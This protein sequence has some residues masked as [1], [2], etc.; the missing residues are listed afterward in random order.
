MR[1][2]AKAIVVVAACFLLATV[3]P[4]VLL[5]PFV[6]LVWLFPDEVTQLYPQA[7]EAFSQ[8][9][10]DEAEQ[11]VR[12][13]LEVSEKARE[14]AEELTRRRQEGQEEA[15]QHDKTSLCLFFHPPAQ[16]SIIQTY[17]APVIH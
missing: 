4:L 6:G 7:V 9:R 13:A 14:G 11:L 8:G 17:Q 12:R 2:A 15:L 3:A 1:S 10:L 5:A 16:E